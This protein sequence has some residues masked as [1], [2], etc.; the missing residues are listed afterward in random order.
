MSAYEQAVG[1][2]Y[3]YLILDLHAGS[4]QLLKLQTNIFPGEARVIFAPR[5]G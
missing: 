1:N 2:N 5:N 4:N 3:G